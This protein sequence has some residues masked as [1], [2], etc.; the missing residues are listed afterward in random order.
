MEM[1][2]KMGVKI[3]ITVDNV[4]EVGKQLVESLE[5]QSLSEDLFNDLRNAKPEPIEVPI[6]PVFERGENG[7]IEE[8]GEEL[9]PSIDEA[10]GLAAGTIKANAEVEEA[11]KEKA[12]AIA[13]SLNE[14]I[15]DAIAQG[16][17]SLMESLGDALV[18]GDWSSV[19]VSMLDSIGSAL[20]SFGST[21]I[22]YA[23]AVEAFKQCFANPYAA[24]A[25]GAAL[26]IAG[27]ALSAVA[28]KL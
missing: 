14:G 25:A 8:I 2:S 20:K 1:A 7:E 24:V 10:L 3:D 4:K 9:G 17:G 21:L 23:I 15:T 12:E 16:I 18:S 28:S 27:A 26:I 22:A 13:K 5:L 11:A 19:L 6:K